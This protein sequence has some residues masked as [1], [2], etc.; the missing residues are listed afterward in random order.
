MGSGGYD[1]GRLG[2]EVVLVGEIVKLNDLLRDTDDL[3]NKIK[4]SIELGHE[5]VGM[6][7]TIRELFKILKETMKNEA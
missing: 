3:P 1:F 2:S 6:L 5:I 7:Q 4:E